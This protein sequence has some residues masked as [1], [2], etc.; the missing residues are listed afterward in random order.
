M[1]S[2]QITETKSSSIGIN[3]QHSSKSDCTVCDSDHVETL[4]QKDN[5]NLG[6]NEICR[7]VTF[8]VHPK[9]LYGKDGRGGL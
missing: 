6:S 5:N 9:T 8:S 4:W 7:A 3:K 1:L 2:Y